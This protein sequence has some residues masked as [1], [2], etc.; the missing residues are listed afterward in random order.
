VVLV[1]V[2]SEMYAIPQA[3]IDHTCLAGSENVPALDLGERLHV[4]SGESSSHGVLIVCRFADRQVGLS[5]DGIAGR[6]EAVIKPLPRYARRPYLLGVVVTAAGRVVLVLD[7][8][9]L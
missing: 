5:V 1:R 9:Q 6:D 2:G 4:P 8:E 7:V 3:V